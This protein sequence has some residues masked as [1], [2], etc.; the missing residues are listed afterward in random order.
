MAEVVDKDVSFNFKMTL[1]RLDLIDILV[2][3]RDLSGITFY[4]QRGKHDFWTK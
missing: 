3:D 2:D 1:F 4:I